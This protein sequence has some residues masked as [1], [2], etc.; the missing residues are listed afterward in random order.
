MDGSKPWLALQETFPF[1]SA[2]VEIIIHIETRS[3][4]V[5]HWL[6]KTKK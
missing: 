2:P 1:D 3:F 6:I 5:T 4:I